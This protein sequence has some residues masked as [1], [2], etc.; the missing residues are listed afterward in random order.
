MENVSNINIR[1]N[2]KLKKQSDIL[3]KE[4]GLNMTTAISMFLTKCVDTA[5]IP[6]KI[7][8]S[9]PNS[10]L[11]NSIAEGNKI[12]DDIKKG[13]RKGYTNMEDLIK[14]LDED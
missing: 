2:S 13:K 4:L 5:S 1:I 12:L 11:L 6:F 14:S 7:E 8:K 3:F 9:K 10:D